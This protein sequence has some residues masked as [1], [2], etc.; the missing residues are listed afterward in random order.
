M[1]DKFK[2][3]RRVKL[4]YEKKFDVES[5]YELIKDVTF[6]TVMFDLS[7]PEAKCIIQAYRANLAREMIPDETNKV[8]KELEKRIDQSI[9]QVIMKR[10]CSGVFIRIGSRSPKD[11]PIFDGYNIK[12]CERM[13]TLLGK[14]MLKVDYGKDP[15]SITQQEYYAFCISI[16]NALKITSGND[17]MDLI[18]NSERVFTDLLL[19][20]EFPDLYSAKI[21][22]R[23]WVTIPYELE[24]RCFVFENTLTAISQYDYNIYLDYLVMNRDI[25]KNM[26][27]DFFY[28][29][30]QKKLTCYGNYVIDIGITA[31]KQ[32][33]YVIEIN[34]FNNEASNGTGGALFDWARD[35]QILEKG[36][37]ELRINEKAQSLPLNPDWERYID[38]LR[39]KT[40]L[41]QKKDDLCVL[42]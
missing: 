9:K 29:H 38:V 15:I 14:T 1:N 25:I 23:E 27:K 21:I 8:L 37:L 4:E 20:T 40:K 11:A 19:A 6:P 39:E 10:N 12:A 33:V 7:L 42:Q 2:Q 3:A 26:I 22:I 28:K 35:K 34:P 5:W 32:Q 16:H 24:F 36:P 17:A 13:K 30:C 41:E 31:K 18:L